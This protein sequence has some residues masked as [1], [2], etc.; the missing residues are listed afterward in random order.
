MGALILVIIVIVLVAV[1]SVQNAMPVAISFLAWQFG[2]SLALIALLFFLCGMITGIGVLSW[3]QMRRRARK[4]RAE[5][6]K[7]P[8]GEKFSTLR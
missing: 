7:Q 4:K 6:E 2:A 8:N 1:F 5:G 3:I